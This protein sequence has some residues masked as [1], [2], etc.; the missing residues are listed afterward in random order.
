[1]VAVEKYIRDNIKTIAIEKPVLGGSWYV[2]SV[3]VNPSTKTGTVRYED[4]HIEKKSN[5]RYS[6][7]GIKIRV[8]LVQ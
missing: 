2:T 3:Y 7:D 1:M 6:M 4:G 8:T 5:F